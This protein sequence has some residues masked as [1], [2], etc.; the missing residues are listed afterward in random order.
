MGKH[1]TTAVIQR[2]VDDQYSEILEVC[3]GL[4]SNSLWRRYDSLRE[5]SELK[6]AFFYLVSRLLEEGKIRFIRPDEDMLFVAGR[7]APCK[8]IE[9]ESTHWLDSDGSILEY[10]S[11]RWP[12]NA[13]TFDDSELNVYFYE[14]PPIIWRNEDG[15]WVGS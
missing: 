6:N 10:L 4:W 11:K 7:P 5:F 8:T 1:E 15:S 9:D 2:A 3:F 12:A 14:I 13:S